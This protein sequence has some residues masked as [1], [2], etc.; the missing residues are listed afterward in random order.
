MKKYG[1][2][3]IKKI[4]L[5][6]IPVNRVTYKNLDNRLPQNLTVLFRIILRPWNIEIDSKNWVWICHG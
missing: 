3:Q 2:A 4:L 5:H 1:V 6:L